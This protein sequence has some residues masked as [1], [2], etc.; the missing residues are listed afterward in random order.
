MGG[1]RETELRSDSWRRILCA[2]R[3]GRETGAPLRTTGAAPAAADD[4]CNRSRAHSTAEP[5]VKRRK[6]RATLTFRPAGKKEEEEKEETFFHL[7]AEAIHFALLLLLMRTSRE[8]AGSRQLI[9]FSSRSR[10]ISF[11]LLES[12]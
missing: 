8:R 6:A 4:D 5:C 2:L 3:P 12:S 1:A 7:D 9:T 10:R 11:P